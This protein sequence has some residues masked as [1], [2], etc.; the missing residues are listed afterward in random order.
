[1]I[2]FDRVKFEYHQEK[3]SQLFQLQPEISERR[4]YGKD[5]QLDQNQCIFANLSHFL[6]SD[7][8]KNCS[9][10][11]CVKTYTSRSRQLTRLQNLFSPNRRGAPTE[12]PKEL[13]LRLMFIYLVYSHS[14]STDH[15]NRYK[16]TA[17]FA[18]S[19]VQG[20]IH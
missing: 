19:K 14:V 17:W 3:E 12:I 15:R 16:Y 6:S 11:F 2:V 9:N 8:A 18:Q 7:L 10:L 13:N 5:S 20:A 1:M 4:L